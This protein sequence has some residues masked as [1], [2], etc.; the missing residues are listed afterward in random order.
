VGVQ[1]TRSDT[2]RPSH[3]GIFDGI[4]YSQNDFAPPDA[5]RY[6]SPP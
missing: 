2:F 6:R 1:N 5:F 4:S 3:T